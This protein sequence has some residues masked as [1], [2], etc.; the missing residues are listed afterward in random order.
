MRTSRMETRNK[1]VPVLKPTDSPCGHRGQ[2]SGRH[3]RPRTIDRSATSV[4]VTSSV[5][6]V[7]TS[8]NHARRKRQE[9]HHLRFVRRGPTFVIVAVSDRKA[10]AHETSGRYSARVGASEPCR[11]V[12][13]WDRPII[14]VLTRSRAWPGC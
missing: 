10:G 3:Q 1:E 8:H 5:N 9:N 7:A 12:A 2:A 6:L 13:L 14:G 4:H 11:R